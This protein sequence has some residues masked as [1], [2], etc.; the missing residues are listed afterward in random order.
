MRIAI[1]ITTQGRN[2]STDHLVQSLRENTSL[3]HDIHVVDHST[4]PDGLSPRTTLWCPDRQSKGHIWVQNIALNMVRSSTQYDYIWFLSDEVAVRTDTDPVAQ[5]VDV[6]ERNPRMAI[7]SPTD[8]TGEHPGSTPTTKESWHAVTATAHTGFMIR[9]QAIDEVGFLNGNLQYC[10]GAMV[11]LSYK[12]YTKGWFVA[13][14][15]CVHAHQPLTETSQPGQT[16]QDTQ[17]MSD[18]FAFDYMFSN[19]GWDWSYHFLAATSAHN[20][21]VDGYAFF[22]QKWAQSFTQQ[23]LEVRQ[24]AIADEAP[25]LVGIAQKTPAPPALVE[26]PVDVSINSEAR[27]KLL[28]W[29]KFDSAADLETMIGEYGRLLLSHQDICLCVRHDPERDIDIN[30]A[31]AAMSLAHERILGDDV[32]LH[33]LLVNDKIDSKNWPLLG[34]YV[35]GSLMLPS[36]Q[37]DPERSLFYQ[38]LGCPIYEDV[39]AL[40]REIAGPPQIPSLEDLFPGMEQLAV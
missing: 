20:I 15:D 4:S 8:P 34:E 27:L 30:A 24:L 23:E 16:A 1:V 19:Y 10:A 31:C 36:S 9:T 22:H 35:D 13:Y 26:T 2:L 39:T 25:L 12:L 3:P 21:Q 18:R 37:N 38:A 5:L 40:R 11:E 33:L 14:A 29:P 17:R 6:L 32:D 7:L 28:V